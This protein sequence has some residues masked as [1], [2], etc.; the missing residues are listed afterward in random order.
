MFRLI[1]IYFC[2]LFL[3][4]CSSPLEKSVVEHL[5]AKELDKVAGEDKSFLATY[6]IVEEKSN[7]IS[8]PSDSAR[9][10]QL[11][12]SRFHNF[13]RTIESNEH[14]APLL[15]SLRSRWENIAAKNNAS[16]DSLVAFWRNFMD[17][18]N[19]DSLV[20]VSF[21][22]VEFERIRNTNKE[23][24][25][26]LRARIKLKALGIVIDSMLLAYSFDSLGMDTLMLS[27]KISDS[28][29]IKFFPALLPHIR[30]ALIN[31][32]S[33]ISFSSIPISLYSDGKCYNMDSL[34][35]EVPESILEYLDGTGDRETVIKKIIDPNFVS[36]SAYLR[37][38]AQ[39][40]YRQTDSLAYS[41]MVFRGEQ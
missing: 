22:G 2:A 41:Y 40:Y 6:S 7:Y 15:S 10:Q 16:A 12:Y 20:S 8:T 33:T 29:L 32:D 19:P 39:E 30:T 18:N 23:I 35:N 17:S 3:A 34:R 5:S 21:E 24:D 13:L 36:L 14:N 4:A 11:T 37:H 38:N 9:W 1:A 26:L 27:R 31:N 28:S 25:T